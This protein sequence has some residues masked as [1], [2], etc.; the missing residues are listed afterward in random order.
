[1]GKRPL[2]LRYGARWEP[3]VAESMC[4]IPGPAGERECKLLVKVIVIRR[5]Y[6][7]AA[8]AGRSPHLVAAVETPSTPSP[9]FFKIRAQCAQGGRELADPIRHEFACGLFSDTQEPGLW[10]RKQMVGDGNFQ[11]FNS[12]VTHQFS[13]ERTRAADVGGR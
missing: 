13:N 4:Q 2:G 6:L 10:S 3:C 11:G 5:M 7:G 12:G 9:R 8:T 1:M